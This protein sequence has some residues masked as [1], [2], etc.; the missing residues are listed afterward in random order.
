MICSNC[1]HHFDDNVKFCP[2]CGAKVELNR[3]CTNCGTAVKSD[4]SFC[5]SCGIP[6]Q[7]TYSNI[8]PLNTSNITKKCHFLKTASLFL[9]GFC[10]ASGS[11]PL[12]K[13]SYNYT[14]G[15]GDVSYANFIS[16]LTSVLAN[17]FY[18]QYSEL[19]IKSIFFLIII[20]TTAVIFCSAIIFGIFAIK[21]I[22]KKLLPSL[23]SMLC[24]E[25]FTLIYLSMETQVS[26][27]YWDISISLFGWIMLFVPI[28]NIILQL[29]MYYQRKKQR[30]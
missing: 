27:K 3:F 6:L 19:N 26:N 2:M 20:L 9:T 24:F 21:N 18:N 15:I 23:C 22:D 11:L 25:L 17:L 16:V 7:K 5:P 29:Y 12:V 14:P 1:H 13:Y 28:I 4:C 30:P 10:F 8:H